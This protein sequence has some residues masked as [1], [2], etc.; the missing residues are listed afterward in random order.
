[1]AWVVSK[2]IGD[3]KTPETAFRTALQQNAV[4]ILN[5]D[6]IPVDLKT[7]LPTADFG[8]FEIPDEHVAKAEK[9]CFMLPK[10]ADK[11]EHAQ[12]AAKLAEQGCTVDIAAAVNADDIA[13]AVRQKHELIK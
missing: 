8:L 11:A 13:A 7:G 5:A 12:I 9:D 2:I 1:M 3:G 6:A 10:V 4:A